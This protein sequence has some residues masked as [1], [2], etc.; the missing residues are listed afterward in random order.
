MG[1]PVDFWDKH[2]FTR[3][4]VRTVQRLQARDPSARFFPL[5]PR[6]VT[7]GHGGDWFRLNLLRRIFAVPVEKEDR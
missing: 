3:V 1:S 5:V 2:A 6:P 4:A 7:P